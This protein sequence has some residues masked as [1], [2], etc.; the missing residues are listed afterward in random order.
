MSNLS[1][2]EGTY[3]SPCLILRKR[4][5]YT[6]YVSV[7]Y[8][9]ALSQRSWDGINLALAK[10][11]SVMLYSTLCCQNHKAKSL[12]R[13]KNK[14]DQVIKSRSMTLRGCDRLPCHLQMRFSSSFVVVGELLQHGICT[15]DHKRITFVSTTVIHY[16]TCVC[17]PH[18]Q[19]CTGQ[20]VWS[21]SL[22][23]GTVDCF[24]TTQCS[25]LTWFCGFLLK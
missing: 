13:Q 19:M 5:L 8:R 18:V 15:Q 23:F 1:Y 20:K 6:G 3:F 9:K 16:S 10:K 22:D 12:Q 17:E 14:R 21:L 4:N 24:E 11:P 25:P 7:L 2:C